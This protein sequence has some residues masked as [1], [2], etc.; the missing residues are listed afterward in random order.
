MSDVRKMRQELRQGLHQYLMQLYQS[1][2]TTVGEEEAKKIV[3]EEIKSQYEFFTGETI[4]S[5]TTLDVLR[6]KRS[7]MKALMNKETDYDGQLF[8]AE[9]M[10]AL[11]AAI[12]VLTLN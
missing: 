8:Y 10:D 9:K 5:D 6:Q 12:E 4:A 1:Y 11:D 7:E 3:S 2:L